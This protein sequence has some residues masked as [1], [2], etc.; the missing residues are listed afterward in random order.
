MSYPKKCVSF[1]PMTVIVSLSLACFLGSTAVADESSDGETSLAEYLLG[2][3]DQLAIRVID[4]EET[5]STST[6][7]RIDPTGN[8]DLPLIGPIHA[9]GLTISQLRAQL[10]GKYR[11]YVIDPIVTVTVVE[12]HSQPVTVVGSVHSPGVHQI[13]GPKRLLEVIAIAGGLK[14][15][16]GSKVSITREASSGP[17]PLPDARNDVGGR[18]SVG[19]IDLAGLISGM[20]PSKNITIMP[21]DV[22]SIP[23]AD[24]VYVLGY[25]KKPG[26]FT[27]HSHASVSALE[28][29]AMASGLDANAKPENARILRVVGDGKNRA[30]IATDLKSIMDGKSPDIPLQADDILLIPN[31]V[32]RMLAIRAIEAAVAI[33]TGILIYRGFNH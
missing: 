2:P 11:K 27:V 6:Q 3:Q 18:F 33:G 24:V 29:L 19:E 32:P 20:T 8:I 26:G 10:V 12:F 5:P 14:E 21:H 23:T 4:L 16:A 1:P 31:N 22:L 30:T 9:A 17:L 7:F 15:D 25:V 13:E 28:A